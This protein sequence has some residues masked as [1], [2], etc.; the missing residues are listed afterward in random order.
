MRPILEGRPAQRCAADRVAEE[1]VSRTAQQPLPPD[2]GNHERVGTRTD[3]RAP[4][5]RAPRELEGVM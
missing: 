4:A 3:A 2:F 1:G 5:V